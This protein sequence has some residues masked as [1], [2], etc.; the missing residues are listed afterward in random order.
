MPV[1]TLPNLPKRWPRLLRVCQVRVAARA[2]GKKLARSQPRRD[3]E[4]T[5]PAVGRSGSKLPSAAL[6][7]DW[8]VKGHAE[9]SSSCGRQRQEPIASAL[10]DGSATAKSNRRTP[11]CFGLPVRP[12]RAMT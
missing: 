6:L 3:Q 2:A 7:L 5:S 9:P 8:R 1:S 4:L 10:H 12:A 11:G